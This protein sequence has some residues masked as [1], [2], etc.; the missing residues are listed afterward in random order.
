MTSLKRKI[1]SNEVIVNTKSNFKCHLVKCQGILDN[2]HH[3]EVV[4][5]AMGRATS[6]A[7]ILA[8]QLNSNNHNTMELKPRTYSVD[9]LEP[10]DK[11][12]IIGTDKDNYDPDDP[13]VKNSTRVTHVPAIEIIVRK[14][15]LELDKLRQVRKQAKY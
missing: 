7:I 9:I 1:D 12:P 8:N 13:H 2:I 10:K 14:N 11:R 4:I 5:K 3:D 15:K 6:R